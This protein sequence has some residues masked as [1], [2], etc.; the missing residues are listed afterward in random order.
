MEQMNNFII[1]RSLHFLSL[2]INEIV[3]PVVE[4]KHDERQWEKVARGFIDV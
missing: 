3:I 4:I 1:I 2:L